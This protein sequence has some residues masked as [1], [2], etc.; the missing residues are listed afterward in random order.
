MRKITL[1]LLF[2]VLST[3]CM[4][5]KTNVGEFREMEGKNYTYAKSKQIWLFWGLIP[6]GRTDTPTPQHGNV[7]V[8]TRFNF[9]DF[10]VRTLTAG[11]VMTATV[12]VVAKKEKEESK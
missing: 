6:M 1:F 2:A 7:Q 8:I 12:K 11:I 10:M 9:G 3:G 4:T 5:T